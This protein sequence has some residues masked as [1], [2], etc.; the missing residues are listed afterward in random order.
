VDH[1]DLLL[2]RG[3]QDVSSGRRAGDELRSK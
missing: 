3:A 2:S 1:D